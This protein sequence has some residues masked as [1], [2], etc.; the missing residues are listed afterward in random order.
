MKDFNKDNFNDSVRN[1]F[2][3]AEIQ[4]GNNVWEGD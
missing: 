1:K 3:N 4:P 2:T